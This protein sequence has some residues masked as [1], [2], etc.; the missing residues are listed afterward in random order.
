L[1][2]VSLQ[3]LDDVTVGGSTGWMEVETTIEH[4]QDGRVDL[5]VLVFVL[6]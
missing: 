5:L 4:L 6:D 3:K 2:F 1:Y